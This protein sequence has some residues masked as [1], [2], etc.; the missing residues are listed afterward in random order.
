MK[1]FI[2]KHIVSWKNELNKLA[3]GQT[4]DVSVCEE[5]V[6]VLG[7]IHSNLEAL[8]EVLADA[9][10]QGVV[11]FVCTGDIVG[12]AAN[13]K[14]CLA[15]IREL[16]C[17]SVMG[18][19]DQYIGTDCSVNDFN[20]YAM[21]AVLWSREQLSD[22]ERGW[23]KSLPM[24]LENDSILLNKYLGFND[25]GVVHSSLSEPDKWLYVLKEDSFKKELLEQKMDLVFFGHTHLPSMFEYNEETKEFRS[26]FPLKQGVYQL[27]KGWKRLI[28]PGSVGQPRD[29]NIRASYAIYDSNKKNVEIR[30]IIYDVAKAAKKVEKA[31]LP[32]KNGKR[33]YLGK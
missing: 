29:R 32:L 2:K 27:E 18:N 6:A 22:E 13:P 25:F 1:E 24:V 3:N 30:R 33:L 8:K 12:Y 20:L 14:E 9:K 26:D 17:P 31:G 7:D 11:K 21:N 16:N 5:K 10:S 28:N 4:R 23:L 19:H 15:V